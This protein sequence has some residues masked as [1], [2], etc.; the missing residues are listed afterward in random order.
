M[1]IRQRAIDELI[2]L[3]PKLAQVEKIL[4][5]MDKNDTLG[6]ISFTDQ[7]ERLSHKIAKQKGILK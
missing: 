5:D 6:R 3:E 1:S 4:K 2:W 7:K